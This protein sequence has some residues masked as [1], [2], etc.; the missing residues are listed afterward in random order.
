[1]HC[2]RKATNGQLKNTDCHYK[3][4]KDLLEELKV[5]YNGEVIPTKEFICLSYTWDF[6]YTGYT[7]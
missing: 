1:M 7:M 5:K 3:L 4:H 6:A 2:F